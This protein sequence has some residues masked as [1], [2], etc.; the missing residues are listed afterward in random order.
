MATKPKIEEI[1]V[2]EGKDDTRRLQEVFNVDTIETIGSA[3][4]QG[5]LDQIE[6]AQETRGVIV[7]TDPDF[8]GEKIRKIIM[9]AVPDAKHAFLPR[10]QAAPKGKGS[11]GVEHA[12][13]QA[14]KEALQKVVTPIN[15]QD[16]A[17]NQPID[18][19]LLLAFGLIAGPG[20]K[21]NRERL[22]DILRIGYT[23][24]KQLEKRLAM[25]RI[26]EAEFAAAMKIV[27]DE[28]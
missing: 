14:L 28:Q 12:S 21:E 6:L 19:Q 11:L 24:G 22:G 26:T 1:I 7:F 9:E 27:E 20:A 23:N 15:D 10:S 4:D 16:A 17:E 25:F 18:R 2:V 13:H 3:I 5:I 8:S